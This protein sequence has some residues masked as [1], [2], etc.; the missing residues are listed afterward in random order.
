LMSLF[1]LGSQAVRRLRSRK[2]RAGGRPAAADSESAASAAQ[3]HF[4]IGLQYHRDGELDEAI[5]RYRQAIAQDDQFGLAYYN[6]GLAYWAKGRTPLATNAFRSAGR[7]TDDA[8]LRGQA[9][10][11]LREMGAAQVGPVPPPLGPGPVPAP[12]AAGGTAVDP[13]LTR[14]VWRRLA[15]GGAAMV[16]LAFAAWGVVTAITMAAMMG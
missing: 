11:R 8:A 16:L 15:W 14:T 9:E 12:T 1:S 13:T 2:P 3:V 6:L 7:S 10:L 4:Q 5:V